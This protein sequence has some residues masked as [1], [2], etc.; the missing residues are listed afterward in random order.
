MGRNAVGEAF[1]PR[2]ALIRVGH[3]DRAGGGQRVVFR[4]FQLRLV[5]GQFGPVVGALD[6]GR[7]PGFQDAALAVGYGEVDV[8]LNGFPG[9]QFLN[10]LRVVIQR[11]IVVARSGIEMKD[12]DVGFVGLPT[13]IV[14]AGFPLPGAGIVLV[15]RIGVE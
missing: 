7:G 10:R 15:G 2:A 4:H 12:A 9:I 13:L 14:C 3:A 11:E 6:I 8:T 5:K 1:A